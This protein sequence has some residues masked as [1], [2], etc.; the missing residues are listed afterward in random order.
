MKFIWDDIK[1]A[2]NVRKHGVPLSQAEELFDAP[3]VEIE[4]DRR[5]YGER[6]IICYG[7]IGTRVYCCVYTDRTDTRRI[8]SLRKANK[9]ESDGYFIKIGA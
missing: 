6:R 9:D 5:D 1:N 7:V 2:A 4:D 3:T 8:I